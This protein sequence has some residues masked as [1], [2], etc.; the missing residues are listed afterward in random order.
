MPLIFFFRPMLLGTR[1]IR[2][3]QLLRDGRQHYKSLAAPT[4]VLFV[5][6]VLAFLLLLLMVRKSR[7]CGLLCRRKKKGGWERL[8]QHSRS[9]QQQQKRRNL[10]FLFAFLYQT[11]IYRTIQFGTTSLYGKK[12]RERRG[13]ILRDWT[14][15]RV[16]VVVILFPC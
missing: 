9:Q 7:C 16:V 1:I 12:Q 13:E 5:Y 3:F 15:S 11:S 10:K 6:Q 8:P 4:C 2:R 14:E